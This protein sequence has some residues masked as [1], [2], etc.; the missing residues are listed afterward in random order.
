[1]EGV[2]MR[3]AQQHDEAEM[4]SNSS[5]ND[6]FTTLLRRYVSRRSLLRG[7]ITG[8]ALA[9]ASTQLP[10]SRV[11]ATASGFRPLM[12]DTH[13]RLLVPDGYTHSVVIRWGD[14]LGSDTPAFDPQAQTGAKQARQFGYNCDFTGFIPLPLGSRNSTHG[15]L[16]VNN[17][18][19]NAEIMFPDWDGKIES[20]TREM[21]DIELAAHGVSMVEVE[22]DASGAWHYIADSTY[23]RRVTGE[24]PIAMSGP[25]AGH[26]WLCTSY[27]PGGTLVRGTLNNCSGGITPW[28][29]LLTCEENFDAYFGGA[30]DAVTDA[31]VRAI[32]Q[33]YGVQDRYGWPRY[34]ERFDVTKEPHEPLRFGW[35][36]EIDPSD[37]QAVPIKR[38]ALG[39]AKHEAATA[40]VTPSG[41][42][43]VYSGD[44]QRLEY[45]YKFVSAGR[46]NAGNRAANLQLL[47][48][49]T[50]YVAK[51]RDDGSGEWLPLAFGQGPLTPTN[52][53]QSQAEVL[54][55]T[56]R[57]ADLLGATK[58][59]R[60][61]DIEA[62]P[63]TGKV[64]AVMTNNTSRQA[65]QVDA[66]NPRPNNKYGHIIELV[67]AGGDHAATQFRWDIFLACGDPTNPEHRTSYQGHQDVSW[68]ATPDNIA[69]D[70]AGR[71]W[72][73]TDGQPEAIKVNDALYVVDTEGPERGR[74][75]MFLSG[76]LGSEICGPAFTPDNRTLFVAI[77]HPGEGKGS[78]F[79]QP[80]SRWPD[81]H[82][83]PRPSIVAVYRSDGGT[84]GS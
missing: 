36:V 20:K 37:P 18:Y 25:A 67:E 53:F 79:A 15:L 39:R 48:A 57:A 65:D 64:Y 12:H 31:T 50:L 76:P 1:M 84:I 21:V 71:M 82:T 30:L 7:G 3:H 13:D 51:F 38:T 19:T 59:D 77:Q 68:L 11:T 4:I 46:Y 54:I 33:R 10:G 60:P 27:D 32:H 83:P 14:A 56:R 40:V 80:V 62:H 5:Q 81:G 17:E 34:H 63:K 70:E 26:A 47:D 74:T 35:V 42:V 29:T 43:V 52:G 28:G 45:V 49:G 23:N 55:N 41:Q 24:T 75:R 22:R 78:T 72:I 61:E 9:T 73:A 8:L 69:F 16:V 66:A 44:D 2:V 58:M 6:T